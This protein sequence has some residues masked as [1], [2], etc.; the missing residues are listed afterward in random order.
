MQKHCHSR[1]AGGGRE[2]LARHDHREA[3]ASDLC[4]VSADVLC[5]KKFTARTA[6]AARPAVEAAKL[7]MNS[8]SSP[9]FDELMNLFIK[10]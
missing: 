5:T 3:G 8:S 7:L 9:N 4:I 1:H 10:N 6:P 2:A